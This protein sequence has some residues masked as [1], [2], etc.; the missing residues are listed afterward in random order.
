MSSPKIKV[1]LVD[2]HTI[3]RN[4]IKSILSKDY[5]KRF[6]IVHID[7]NGDGLTQKEF[8]HHAHQAKGRGCSSI[9]NRIDQLHGTIHFWNNIEISKIT[10][11][12]P[13]EQPKN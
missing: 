5:K 7:H 11:D 9:L 12:I 2:D 3:L 10:I 6:D 8:M 1:V 4:G 13:Y